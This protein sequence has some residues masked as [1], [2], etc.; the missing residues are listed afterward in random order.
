MTIEDEID[1]VATHLWTHHRS[2]VN[3]HE[4]YAKRLYLSYKRAEYICY[5]SGLSASY[6]AR[7]AN[8]R[9]ILYWHKVD[10][11]KAINVKYR[12]CY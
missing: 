1:V 3:E 10:L 6:I 4:D 12:E 7:L 11:E 2:L 9:R 5:R 8:T